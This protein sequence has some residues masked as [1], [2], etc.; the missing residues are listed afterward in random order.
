MAKSSGCRIYLDHR[1]WVPGRNVLKV[2]SVTHIAGGLR[3]PRQ[4]QARSARSS[5]SCSLFVRPVSP[6]PQQAWST[7]PRGGTVHAADSDAH[8]RSH[9]QSP[10]DRPAGIRADG[11][12]APP[13]STDGAS[14]SCRVTRLARLSWFDRATGGVGRR[15]EHARP[16][17]VVHL[18]VE[19]LSKIP[20]GGRWRVHR[21]R[22]RC[23]VLSCDDDPE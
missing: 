21:P 15:Y 5:G 2:T 14:G 19:K 20:N 23:G 1:T 6:P 10:R 11:L 7:N 4:Y 3:V 16:G 22:D 13:A 17:V 9:H 18:D 12:P 8:R